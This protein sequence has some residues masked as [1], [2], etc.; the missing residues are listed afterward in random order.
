MATYVSPVINNATKRHKAYADLIVLL[1]HID[2]GTG[3]PVAYSGDILTITND[4]ITHIITLTTTTDIPAG[5][6]AR[7]D[8]TK[9]A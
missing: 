5:Q 2:A 6:L 7:Y 3:S 9:T 1:F 4:Q 8:L